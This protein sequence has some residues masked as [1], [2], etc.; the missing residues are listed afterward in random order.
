MIKDKRETVD[1]SP[2]NAGI[3]LLRFWNDLIPWPKAKIK[4]PVTSNNAAVINNKEENAN[5]IPNKLSLKSTEPM[6]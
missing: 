2:N 1:M 6:K 4:Y 3:K 5:E